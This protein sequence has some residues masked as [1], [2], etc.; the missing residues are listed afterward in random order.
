MQYLWCGFTISRISSHQNGKSRGDFCLTLSW[1]RRIREEEDTGI[2]VLYDNIKMS[3]KPEM[4]IRKNKM[5]N[6]YFNFSG[7]YFEN[8]CDKRGEEIGQERGSRH[9][10]CIQI[11]NQ[12]STAQV[13]PT[14][15]QKNIIERALATLSRACFYASCVRRV[16][17]IWM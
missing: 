9:H 14:D 13:P 16:D 12:H 15:A 6:D 7:F 5:N 17:W 4:T 1:R 11:Y 10:K 3:M 8:I 2:C